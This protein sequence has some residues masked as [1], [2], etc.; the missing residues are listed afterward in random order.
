[1]PWWGWALV[2]WTGLSFVLGLLIGRW[3]KFVPLDRGGA[4]LV[5]D[6]EEQMSRFEASRTVQL[7]NE[8]ARECP[9]CDG[10]EN[11]LCDEGKRLNEEANT[12]CAL[13]ADGA[14]RRATA[15]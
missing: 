5:A 9:S 8:H 3:L 13:G 2:G 4:G 11:V 10:L 6:S 12:A 14:W 15:R 1:M 7:F